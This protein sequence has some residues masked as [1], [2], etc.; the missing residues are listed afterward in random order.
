MGRTRP[1]EVF[2][3][4]GVTTGSAYVTGAVV[5]SAFEIKGACGVEGG[6]LGQTKLYDEASGNAA[7]R[8]H[9]Y[10]RQ[11]SAI[12]N[13]SAFTLPAVDYEAHLGSV[14]GVTGWISAGASVRYQEIYEP[15]VSLYSLSGNR[16]IWGRFES[17][18]Q[19]TWGDSANP[20]R[21]HLMV[22]QD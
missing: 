2:T 12:P 5:G 9:F 22:L 6:L 3:A 13:G 19:Y 18:G 7:L 11:P 20:L 17:L 14:T 4:L 10:S 8:L 1:S 15:N 16:S 21:G